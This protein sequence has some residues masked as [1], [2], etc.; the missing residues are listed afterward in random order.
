MIP[1]VTA[2]LAFMLLSAVQRGLLLD[3]DRLARA[4]LRALRLESTPTSYAQLVEAS[5]HVLDV[6]CVQACQALSAAGHEAEA[7]VALD[8]VRYQMQVLGDDL[9]ERWRA[10]SATAALL[11]AA[12]PV[13]PLRASA[14]R[15]PWLGALAFVDGLARPLLTPL[16]G[17]RLHL[18]LLRLG[19]AFARRDLAHPAGP[20]RLLDAAADFATLARASVAAHDALLRAP[21][22]YAQVRLDPIA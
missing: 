8:V 18:A 11:P 6:A 14:L 9:H 12:V 15:L 20:T 21:A 22:V 4:H 2:C 17:L 3:G 19:L 7:R 10:W 5:T 1:L 16:L 13:A